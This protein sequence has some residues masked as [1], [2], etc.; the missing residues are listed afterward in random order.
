MVDPIWRK[1][2]NNKKKDYEIAHPRNPRY[3]IIPRHV[4]Q[5]TAP[6]SWRLRKVKLLAKNDARCEL[7]N[8]SVPSAKNEEN[9]TRS[10][11]IEFGQPRHDTK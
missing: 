4:V 11:S 1:N 9:S 3:I 6:P 5:S 10:S 7:S 2:K 8:F